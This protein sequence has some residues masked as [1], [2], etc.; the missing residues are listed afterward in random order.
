MDQTM[1]LCSDNASQTEIALGNAKRIEV[2][3]M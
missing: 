3:E 2:I 1:A